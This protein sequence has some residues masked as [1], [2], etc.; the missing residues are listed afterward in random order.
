MLL[1][2]G[3]VMRLN[4]VTTLNEQQPSADSPGFLG[5][6]GPRAGKRES[7]LA[8]WAAPGSTPADRRSQFRHSVDLSLRSRR[9][10]QG[11]STPWRGR[12]HHRLHDGA[13]AD[14]TKFCVKVR[15]TFDIPSGSSRR[16]LNDAKPVPKS[17]S[18]SSTLLRQSGPVSPPTSRASM[19][20]V[21]VIS[22]IRLPPATP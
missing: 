19:S 4:S 9:L 14:V 7:T 10:P 22:R 1:Q 5:A 6:A 18:A 21:S 13:V 20:M 16:L 2:F 12:D 15:S 11:R 8:G 3:G 17:S